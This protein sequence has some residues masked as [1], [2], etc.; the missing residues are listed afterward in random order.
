MRLVDDFVF[1]VKDVKSGQM[2]YKSH[3]D[4]EN[5]TTHELRMLKASIMF[6]NKLN[7]LQKDGIYHKLNLL[8]KLRLLEGPLFIHALLQMI[9]LTKEIFVL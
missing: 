4:E 3:L 6:K 2:K 5:Q 8:V 9:T 1:Q 7:K